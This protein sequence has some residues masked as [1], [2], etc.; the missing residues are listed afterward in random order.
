MNRE[1]MS[2]QRVSAADGDSAGAGSP[3]VWRQE[4]LWLILNILAGIAVGTPFLLAAG[5]LWGVAEWPVTI[6]FAT[7]GVV[8][9]VGP[10]VWQAVSTWQLSRWLAKEEEHSDVQQ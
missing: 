5:I 7:G 9:L 1:T 6:T 4:R 8:L 3:S 10:G 2:G